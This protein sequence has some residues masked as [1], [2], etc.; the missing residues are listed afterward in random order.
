[1][2]PEEAKDRAERAR[3]LLADEMLQAAFSDTRDALVAA[4][5]VAKTPEESYK[6]AIALQTF[7]LIKGCIESHIHTAKVI[8]YNTKKP[9]LDRV[10]GR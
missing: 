3:L 4:V 5:T 2:T 10:L 7:E 6:A 1:M 9:F 8:E